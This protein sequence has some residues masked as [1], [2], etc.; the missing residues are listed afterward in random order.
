MEKLPIKDEGNEEFT[1]AA[2]TSQKEEF[3]PKKQR[4]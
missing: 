3:N 4:I 1:D 2:F